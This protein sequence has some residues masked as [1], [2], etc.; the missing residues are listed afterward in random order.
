MV[1]FKLPSGCSCAYEKP[2]ETDGH[3]EILVIVVQ[4]RRVKSES[5]RCR[6]MLLLLPLL[7]A[8]VFVG[9]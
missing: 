5:E 8:S 2:E 9:L 3:G 7:W 4:E 6:C 1:R